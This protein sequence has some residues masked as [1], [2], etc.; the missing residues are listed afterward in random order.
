MGSIVGGEVETT[1]YQT[2]R[3]WDRDRDRDVDPGGMAKQKGGVGIRSARLGLTWLDLA[4][5][6]QWITGW[7][8]AIAQ[9]WREFL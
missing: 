9:N 7:C 3:D 5:L 4:W 8:R 1:G 2:V 6:F